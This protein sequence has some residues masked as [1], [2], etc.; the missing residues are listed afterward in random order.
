MEPRSV[1][2]NCKLFERFEVNQSQSSTVHDERFVRIE[3]VARSAQVFIE[4]SRRVLFLAGKK[5]RSRNLVSIGHSGSISTDA[6]LTL[7]LLLLLPIRILSHFEQYTLRETMTEL[8]ISKP[9]NIHPSF[10]TITPL[11]RN[12]KNIQIQR[13]SR[14]TGTLFRTI[15][16]SFFCRVGQV[17]M[18]AGTLSRS[19]KTRESIGERANRDPSFLDFKRERRLDQS[20]KHLRVFLFFSFFPVFVSFSFFL[21]P[22]PS[23]P[24]SLHYS[25]CAIIVVRASRAPVQYATHC[26]QLAIDSTN[27]E[28]TRVRDRS[29][30]N[31]A[32]GGGGGPHVLRCCHGFSTPLLQVSAF[33]EF[34]LL[35]LTGHGGLFSPT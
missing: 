35:P 31:R 22:L 26:R 4:I 10:R 34:H 18:L 32:R 13:V 27:D 8:N 5:S 3:C 14:K 12:S 9:I 33:D 16:S 7:L 24:P 30:G 15:V 19:E 17:R 20:S 28:R 29:R 6:Q 23:S 21:F 11:C 1:T 25:G 2:R